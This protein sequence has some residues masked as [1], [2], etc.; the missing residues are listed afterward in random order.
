V[1][2]GRLEARRER[3]ARARAAVAEERARIA[4]D[5]HDVVSQALGVIVMQAG[6]AGSMAELTDSDARAVLRTI[7][8][9]GRHAFAEMRSLVT[10]LRTDDDAINHNP[11]P[12]AAEIP[13]LVARLSEAGLDVVLKVDG[14]ARSVPAGVGVSAY[15]IVQESLTNAL[16]HADAAHVIVRLAWSP[17]CLRIEVTDDG[18]G[19][20]VP[21]RTV[22]G[23]I[24]GT[25]LIGMR[26]RVA[27]V[28]GQIEAGPLP[29]GGYR[30]AAQL[31]FGGTG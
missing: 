21:G 17:G 1:R 23:P 20:S 27:L 2:A 24:G 19:A 11:Q 7:E 30:V 26:E 25:G 28:G 31:P 10:L 13:A 9:T 18:G 16:K 15:R 29:D 3:E 4:R 22:A 12:T 8:E 5:F 14:D 6:G